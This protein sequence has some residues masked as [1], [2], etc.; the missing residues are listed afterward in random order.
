M[1]CVD[2]DDAEAGLT[3]AARGCCKRGD[4]FLNASTR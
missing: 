1:R 2:L 4:Y 3:S